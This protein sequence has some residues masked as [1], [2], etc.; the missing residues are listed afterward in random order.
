MCKHNHE[1]IK[2]PADEGG[3]FFRVDEMSCTRIQAV[4]SMAR[5]CVAGWEYSRII[6]GGCL[7]QAKL[8]SNSDQMAAIQ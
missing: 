6:S 5:I 8:G 2:S 4:K 1:V 7:D 3:L